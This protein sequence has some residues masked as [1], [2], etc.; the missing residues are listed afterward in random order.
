MVEHD[1]QTCESQVYAIWRHYETHWMSSLIRGAQFEAQSD[2]SKTFDVEYEFDLLPWA[3]ESREAFD[4]YLVS[5]NI[6]TH[7]PKS[8]Q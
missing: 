3:G 7:T 5:V 1:K 2:G 6:R 8:I 4:S